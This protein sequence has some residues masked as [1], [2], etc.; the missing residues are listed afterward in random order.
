MWGKKVIVALLWIIE[1]KK[2]LIWSELSLSGT[3]MMMLE[4]YV[5]SCNNT[6][7][8]Y[9]YPAFRQIKKDLITSIE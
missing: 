8:V 4:Q 5:R 3:G 9:C 2:E 6:N 7:V 1:A